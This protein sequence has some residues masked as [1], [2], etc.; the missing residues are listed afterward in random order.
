MAD[1]PH[2]ETT[3]IGPDIAKL[4]QK[5]LPQSPAT[6][7]VDVIADLVCPWCYL[8]KKRLDHALAAV[9]GPSVVSW[10]PFQLNPDMPVEGMPFEE[11][12]ARKFGDP[13]KLQPGIDELTA[14][15]KTA[16]IELR[17][18]LISQV[19]NTLNAHRLM[20]F[21]ALQRAD[22]SALAERILCGFF[23]QGLDIADPDVLAV[24]GSDQGLGSMDIMAALEDE[25]SKRVVLAQEAQVR[26][27][28]VTGVPDFLVNK[29]LFVVGA[30][31]TESLVSV[32]DRAMFGDESDLTVSPTVH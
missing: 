7:Q 15:A 30:Q 31:R 25:T 24:L 27:S 1:G 8:G 28:G 29:R 13:A 20:S 3:M 14:M 10:Y 6:L 4:S 12:L 2:F 32:F 23:S 5:D 9:H 19:P 26:Q 16:G 22:T 18:D 11:Y 21:A 17:F